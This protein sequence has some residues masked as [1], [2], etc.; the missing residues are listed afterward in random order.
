MSEQLH[1]TNENLKP[2][3]HEAQTEVKH[4]EVSVEHEKQKQHEQR[5]H[6]EKTVE[7]HA[8]SK[9]E[10]P[11]EKDSGKYEQPQYVN[12]EL[13]RIALDRT[14]AR[15]RRHLSAPN[16]SLSK[17]VHVPSVEAISEAGAKTVA[18][19]SGLLAGSFCALLG[20]SS[21][22]YLSKHYGFRYN[23]LFFFVFFVGGFAVG[24]IIEMI[25]RLF[26]RRRIN[27]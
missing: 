16:K 6:A 11:I 5:I 10:T 26:R 3:E 27:I 21:L 20:S 1:E 9:Q 23:Y 17:F 8:K 13:K 14:L 2:R 25:V 19:P 22:L 24:L 12:K 18:R 15:A 4:A 7:H